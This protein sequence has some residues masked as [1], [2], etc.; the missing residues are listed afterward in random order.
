L[1]NG[2]N[3]KYYNKLKLGG[4]SM[5]TMSKKLSI[6][7]VVLLIVMTVAACGSKTTNPVASNATSADTNQKPTIKVGSKNFTEQYILGELYAQALEAAGYPVK[8]VFGLGGPQIGF[9]SLKRGDID[10]FPEYTGTAFL[11]ILKEKPSSDPDQVLAKLQTDYKAKF[12]IDVLNRTEFNNTWVVVTTKEI[13]DKYGIKT[14]S[15][16]AAK[17]PELRFA[18]ITQ[19]TERE[20]GLPGLQKTYGGFKFKSVKLFDEGLK[21]KALTAGQVDITLGYGT[22][23]QI[24]GLGLVALKD[25][26]NFFPPY[27]AAPQVRGDVLAKNPQ[28]G[29]ILNNIDKLLTDPV[30]SAMNWK[31]DGDKKEP[32][33][34]ATEFLKA[35]GFV[36]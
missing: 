26:K 6:I 2:Q 36:K 23:G 32:K 13:S 11:N 14:L 10:I 27:Q 22:D 17:A 12:N 20:D 8:R 7:C 24:A 1:K 34:V 3:H 15:D 29:E 18:S 30:M 4:F 25:D 35:H 9:D 33:D 5:K 16:L 19:F 31:V 28:I 21:Y